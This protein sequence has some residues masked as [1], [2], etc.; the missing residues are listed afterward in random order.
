MLH[1]IRKRPR[2]E[3]E[4]VAAVVEVWANTSEQGDE[5]DAADL[6]SLAHASSLK[7]RNLKRKQKR[8]PQRGPVSSR[9]ESLGQMP[10]GTSNLNQ[11][12]VQTVSQTTLFLI[13]L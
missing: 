1:H 4:G 10:I 7:A 6:R 8:K 11:K 5:V 13:E 9:D 3:V 2:C 12:L